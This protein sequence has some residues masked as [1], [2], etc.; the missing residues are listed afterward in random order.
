MAERPLSSLNSSE[1]TPTTAP[2]TSEGSVQSNQVSGSKP[3]S[4]TSPSTWSAPS[5]SGMFKEESCEQK[6]DKTIN[7]ANE[8]I[9]KAKVDYNTCATKRSTPKAPAS[10]IFSLS[11]FGLGSKPVAGEPTAKMG[12]RRKKTQRKQKNKKG[13]TNKRRLF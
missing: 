7:A 8:T 3:F 5:F 13:K 6:R 10:S 11:Y 4:W 9:K 1:R 2:L 12:G